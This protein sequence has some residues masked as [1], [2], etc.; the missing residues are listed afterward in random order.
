MHVLV[1]GVPVVENRQYALNLQSEVEE[2]LNDARGRGKA[3][4]QRAGLIP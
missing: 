3:T 4:A 1:N 2:I